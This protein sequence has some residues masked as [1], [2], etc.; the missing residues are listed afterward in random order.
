METDH[1]GHRP[2]E[3]VSAQTRLPRPED[4]TMARTPG[5]SRTKETRFSGNRADDD[6]A[7]ADGDPARARADEGEAGD[8]APDDDVVSGTRADFAP[9]GAG[10]QTTFLATLKRTAKEFSEDNLTD[11]AASL[12]YYGVQALFPALLAVL[13]IILLVTDPRTLTDAITAVVPGAAADTIKPVVD[14][15][16]G[17]AGTAG[18]GLILGVLLAIWSASAYVGTFTRAANVVY[19]TPEGRKIWKLKPLQLLVTLIGVLFA[20]VIVAMVVLS[21]PVVEALGGALGI[22]STALSVW[23]IIKWPIIVVLVALMIAVLYYSTPN[24]KLRGFKWVSPG[25]GI[26]LV[27]WGVASALFAFYVANF[28]S[29]NKTYGTLAGVIIFLIWFWLTNVALLFGIELD[30]ELERNREIK[31]GVPRAEKEIQLDARADPKD[32]QTT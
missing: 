18:F 28:G 13:S 29:Y 25:A 9:T 8:P 26:A 11:W 6:R 17:K 22:G 23:S 19:E 7:R 24:V 27:V 16:A 30:A 15:I 14:Q 10:P 12:T 21:G 20:V 2:G 1:T 5:S 31:E 4:R 32:K 3:P